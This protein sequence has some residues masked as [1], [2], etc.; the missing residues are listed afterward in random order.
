MSSPPP[1]PSF[2]PR[3]EFIR[4]QQPP[5]R[6]T[7]ALLALSSA[8]CVRLYS[9][10]AAAAAAVRR[11]LEQTLPILMVRED[12][13]QNL[14]EYTVDGKPWANA[15]SVATEKLLVDI[16]A[17]IYQ[18]GYTYLSTID[19]GREADDRLAMAFSKVDINPPSSRTATPLPPS[20][21][22]ARN[23]SSRSSLGE[24]PKARRV[25][26][27]LS[28]S[29]VTLMRVISP[30]LHLTPAIL[31]AVRGSW[32]R[33]VVSE[34]KVGENSYEFKLKGYRWFQQDT[35]A[36][37]SLQHILALLTS[38]DSH[39]FSLLTSIS[40]T[41][42]SRVKDLW[43]FTGPGPEDG[44]EMLENA[45]NASQPS[46]KR[47]L[48]TAGSSNEP[49]PHAPQQHR[50]LATE[51]LPPISHSPN[52]QHTRA[53]TDS[54]QRPNFPAQPHVLRKPAPRAQIPVS[55]VQDSDLPEQ[56]QQPLI[57]APMPST[58]ST[59]V[60][61]MTGVGSGGGRT[62]DV[63]YDTPPFSANS[64]TH[65]PP[66]V[67]VPT[68]PRPV[69]DVPTDVQRTL[70]PVSDRAKTPPL[71]ISRSPPPSPPRGSFSP[72]NSKPST[73]IAESGP[74]PPLLGGGAFR[75]SAFSSSSGATVEIPIQWTGPL[76]EEFKF[77]QEKPPRL[78]SSR[79]SST[80][81]FPGGWQPTPIAEKAEDETDIPAPPPQQTQQA[82][83]IYELDSR[84]ESPAI[85]QPDM[86]L[87][88]SE[89]ALVDIIQSTSSPPPPVPA[90]PPTERKDTSAS[91]P[92]GQ[93]WVLVNVDSNAASGIAQQTATNSEPQ[94]T[95]SP[96]GPIP[97][98]PKPNGVAKPSTPVPE[99][100]SPAA[101]A[102][103]IV[104]AMESKHKKSQSASASKN[105]EEGSSGLKRFFSLSR[106]NSSP[107]PDNGWFSSCQ[108]SRPR[109]DESGGWW[110]DTT[111]ARRGKGNSGEISK[112]TDQSPQA[113]PDAAAVVVG[114]GALDD[115]ERVDRR[116]TQPERQRRHQLDYITLHA[117][118]PDLASDPEGAQLTHDAELMFTQSL[119]SPSTSDSTP[120]ATQSPSAVNSPNEDSPFIRPPSPLIRPSLLASFRGDGSMRAG[121][122]TLIQALQAL[123][124][125]NSDNDEDGGPEPST[126]SE[127]D[128]DERPQSTRLSSSIHT[129]HRPLA[130]SHR[131]PV[132]IPSKSSLREDSLEEDIL[133]DITSED[134]NEN[135]FEETPRIPE[136]V[137][138][139]LQSS[140]PP[141]QLRP[142][143]AMRER[144]GSLATIR[145]HRR[146]RLAQKL[147]EVY[148]LED[149][150]EK[151]PVGSCV[152]FDQVLK[153]GS[154]NKKAQ[155]TKRWIKHWFVLK[156]DALS[157]YQS[158]SDPYFPHGIVDLRYAISCDPSGEKGFRLRTN[159][160]T[161]VL[162]ADSVPSREEWVK[163]IRKVIFKA[164]NMGDSVKIAIPYSAIVDVE[165]S[166]AM[167]FTE[168]IEIKVVDKEDNFT[169]DS[170]FFAYFHDLAGGLDQIRDAVRSHRSQPKPLESGAPAIVVDTTVARPGPVHVAWTHSDERSKRYF[171]E[172]IV[173]VVAIP[174]THVPPVHFQDT[175]SW[176]VGVPS[177][178]KGSRRVFGG[179]TATTDTST[180]FTATPV[181]EVYSPALSSPSPQS[182]SS[183]GDLAFSVL[184]TPD[185]APD[186]ETTKFRAAFA[187]DEKETLL[188]YF[189]GY[190]YRLLP[191]Y[192]KLYI[193][194]NHF[195]FKS[196]GPLAVR[197]RMTLPIRDILA[198]EKSKAS[199]FGHYGLIIIIKGHEE[200]FFEFNSEDKRE[201]FVHLLDRQME[202]VRRRLASGD[203]VVP[204]SG[205]RE[206]LI[207]EEFETTASLGGDSDP[208]LPTD[209]MADSV[210]AVMFTSASSTFLTFKPRKSLHFT[211]LTIGSRGDVQPYI[212]LAK[213]LMADG[214]RCKIATHGEFQE[215]IESHGIEFGYVGG[216]PAELMRICIEN[217]TFTVSFLKEGLTKFRGWL[218][219]LLKTSWEA[220]QGTDVLIESPSAMGGYHIAEAL[221]IPYFRAF[222]MTWTRTRAY[223]HAFAVPDRK[224]GGSYNYMSYVM[225]DQVFW[226][227]TA[228]QINRW[229]RNILR[230]G[231]TSLDKMEPHKIPFLYNFS[232]HVVPPPLDWPEWIRV[233]G[234]W[235]LEDA[236]VSAK[237]WAP[238]SS[239]V[240]FVDNAH[241]IGHKVVY[242]GFGSI[243]V[244][245]PK[246]MTHCVVEAVLRSGVHAILS[247]DEEPL[248]PQ[249]YAIT[250]VPHDWLFRRIDAACHHG[251]AGTTG[252]SLRAGIPTIIHPF[253]GD[254]FFWADRVEALG[255][256]TG[257]R[258]LTVSA[259]SDAL[260][261]ATND[262]KQIA[263]AK[264]IGEQ[265]R[266]EDGVATAIESIYRDMDYARSLIKQPVPEVDGQD[267]V[268]REDSTIRK[269]ENVS[270]GSFSSTCSDRGA[271]SED[272]SVI[273]DQEDR[274]S[275]VGS[276]SSESWVA[277]EASSTVTATIE[278]HYVNLRS[279]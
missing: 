199:R 144:A 174:R 237:K 278:Q 9:F 82:T 254:Q 248:P 86:A 40:L 150:E 19:Y 99:Q 42:R 269:H 72:H 137:P 147:K 213:G 12:T 105:K 201:A 89:A 17:L 146:T 70:R 84:I 81:M 78:K 263:R 153:S 276:R 238:P 20:S 39:S 30:P 74:S 187:Y 228:G 234:Y 132:P 112:V 44:S 258:K 181:K 277:T 259:L 158:S 230:L 118:T 191:V 242:I 200:L 246:A 123:P 267:D 106:K 241:S 27:A 220:C 165:R 77:D 219:D 63:F 240:Q 131:A 233:T 48:L 247:K 116:Q 69:R 184:E 204:S 149:I 94:A 257:V 85:T 221:A 171:L 125:M 59:G 159:T 52:P 271:P 265:I 3:K 139:H 130:R 66:T 192:G 250:S 46:L 225:F 162:S 249:I 216:D 115:E 272:W 180:T 264:I 179:S 21:S 33:G 124:W 1:E 193:S 231:P 138:T 83:P 194:T 208:A 251:G 207:L 7:F 114:T 152:Q 169:V 198:S 45:L 177:W 29:S 108:R 91:T 157:W 110:W 22:T 76:K 16:I 186:Q 109:C 4:D 227:A 96:E 142:F 212:A 26:F 128:E 173:N 275:S 6:N 205:K 203:N 244:S 61:N 90:M 160:K 122:Q 55:V 8:N 170:Y 166:T 37:D 135:D 50:R 215:W 211:F 140:E 98:S 15:K 197:T 24:K 79:L 127:S 5:P 47:T 13:V 217:G 101:K 120:T 100:A 18:C 261:S 57:R 141:V 64:Q 206:A 136:S 167:D 75:D 239:L 202:D 163:A 232:P 104:D 14:C 175:S 154:L 126:E 279:L 107:N 56:Q 65:F 119:V 62:P 218:D 252:A 10:S 172:A 229:R 209:G 155:R 266:A 143:Q 235:T 35:F 103:V 196:S 2:T 121:T 34:K 274:R 268:M 92:G 54:P 28:F 60:E 25:P 256:G 41:N 80:P 32:P 178:L 93:G 23:D 113:R 262:P 97:G 224:M 214:H 68:S 243:V 183:G 226:R 185:M 270:P 222:T 67:P 189:P 253:F 117:V 11:L 71:L 148:D 168:T 145:L 88:K 111:R 195:C 260:L 188:G 164:Q 223:P 255:V 49:Q 210:P 53:V 87:R 134:D 102:I 73:P 95:S 133:E 43:I 161:V 236:D 51:P 151:C 273:S 31:Q 129:I 176:V 36:T 38:L 58:I 182:R 156:N 245:D 190:I